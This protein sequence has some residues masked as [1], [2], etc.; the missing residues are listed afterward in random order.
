[1]PDE[2][3]GPTVDLWSLAEDVVVE[4]GDLEGEL[5][6]SG[7]W[8]TERVTAPRPVVEEALRR[9]ELGP[10]LLANLAPRADDAA[11]RDDW[12]CLSLHLERLS[13]LIVRTLGIDDLA[14]PLLS[15]MPVSPVAR[16]ALARLPGRRPVRLPSGASLTVGRDGVSVQ[17]PG[18]SYR[19]L[20][21]RPEA[22]WVLG[23]LAWPVTPDQVSAALALPAGVAERIMDYLAAAGMTAAVE[24][25][26]VP[27]SVFRRGDAGSGGGRLTAARETPTEAGRPGAVTA[28]SPPPGRCGSRPP[29]C[30]PGASSPPS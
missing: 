11:G 7:R 3:G 4:P 1:M 8:G 9:M 15:A 25:E 14:G 21:H 5:V 27:S 22:V 17:S 29:G 26:R 24:E 2:A 16:F 18:S 28:A 23:R 20:V 6:L 30:G 12:Y 10:V 19:V 13:H